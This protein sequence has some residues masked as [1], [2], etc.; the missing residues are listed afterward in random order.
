MG[1]E[2][3]VLRI[4]IASLASCILRARSHQTRL[5][6]T[7]AQLLNAARRVF[8]AFFRRIKIKI[9]ST[10]SARRGGAQL[11]NVT[12]G[13][14]G[15]SDQERGGLYCFTTSFL[16]LCG[17]LRSLYFFFLIYREPKSYAFLWDF[18]SSSSHG[19]ARARRLLES[20]L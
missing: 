17:I 8:L 15:Q 10:L 16:F 7:R 1:Q 14:G 9:F 2:V 20:I 6:E 11:I 12:L 4:H 18:S 5:S 3:G 13:Q 19:T